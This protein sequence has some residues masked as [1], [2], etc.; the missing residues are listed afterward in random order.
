MS[1]VR[2]GEQKNYHSIAPHV[3]YCVIFNGMLLHTKPVIPAHHTT[4]SSFQEGLA[5][6]SQAHSSTKYNTQNVIMQLMQ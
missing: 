3:N 1:M 4:P 6:L 5:H 2:D